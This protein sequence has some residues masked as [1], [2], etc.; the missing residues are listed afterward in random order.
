MRIENCRN[1]FLSITCKSNLGGVIVG[2]VLTLISAA[3][4]GVSV[5]CGIR[6]FDTLTH[7]VEATREAFRGLMKRK[8]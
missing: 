4:V 5:Y 2:S 8:G 1:G 7:N 6:N 3:A